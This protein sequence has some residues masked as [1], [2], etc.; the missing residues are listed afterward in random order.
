MTALLEWLA[1]LPPAVLLQGSGTA[2]LFVNAAHILFLGVL[3]GSIVAL[4][5]RVLGL[6]RDIPLSAIAPYLSRVAAGGL[7]L[8]IFTGFWL[9]ITQPEE[10]VTSAAFLVKIALVLLGVLNALWLHASTAWRQALLPDARTP[11]AARLH[12]VASLFIW[13]SAVLAGRWIAFL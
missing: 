8:A 1:S 6:G 7:A 11:R 13:L 5:L 10:Y 2:Y 9:F 3:V 4:D 12:A